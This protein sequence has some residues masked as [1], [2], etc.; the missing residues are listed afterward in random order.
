MDLRKLLKENTFESEIE[1]WRMISNDVKLNVSP[2]CSFHCSEPG[3]FRVCFANMD[4]ETLRIALERI[5]NFVLQHKE[6]NEG[7][8][9]KLTCPKCKLEISLPFRRLDDFMNSRH[10]PISSPLVKART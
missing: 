2:G 7:G 4:D 1:L 8:I 3:W 9:K 5:K 10:S 6:N